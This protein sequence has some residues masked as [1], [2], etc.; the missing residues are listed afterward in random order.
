MWVIKCQVVWKRIKRWLIG[1]YWYFVW[2]QLFFTHCH[3]I[4]ASG[5]TVNDKTIDKQG[6][7]K[8]LAALKSWYP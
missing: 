3:A 8:L 4:G 6:A 7:D 1:L 5:E 2:G